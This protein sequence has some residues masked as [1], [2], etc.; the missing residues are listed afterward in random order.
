M[1]KFRTPKPVEKKHQ[2]IEGYPAYKYKNVFLSNQVMKKHIE[3]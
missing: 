3:Y 2:K 1:G